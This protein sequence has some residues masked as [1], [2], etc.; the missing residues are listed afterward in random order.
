MSYD[1]KIQSARQIVDAHNEN[2]DNLKKVDFDHFLGELKDNGG[3][4][5]ETLQVCSWEDLQAYGLPRLLARKVAELFRAK[6]EVDSSTKSVY[7]SDKKAQM[8][9]ITELLERYNPRD[10]KNAIGKRLEEISNG[11]RCIIFNNNGRVNTEAS[12]A[13]I[14]DLIDGHEELLNTFV[15]GIPVLV[16]RVGERPDSYVDENP[17]YPG[18]ALRS[19]ENCDQTGRSWNGVS[20]VA[21]QLLYIARTQTNELKINSLDEAHNALDKAMRDDAEKIIRQRYPKASLKHEELSS[22][23]KLPTLKLKIGESSSKSNAPFGINKTF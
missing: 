21:R 19:G 9:T 13:L 23:G 1:S 15:N 2:V 5:E 8:M 11:K 14:N 12:E 6:N 16:Y 4:S 3:T 20:H 18:R 17:I 22:L 10:L 7:V